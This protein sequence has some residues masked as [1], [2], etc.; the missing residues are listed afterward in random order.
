MGCKILTNFLVIRLNDFLNLYCFLRGFL[1][2]FIVDI[3]QMNRC[4]LR[5]NKNF[6]KITKIDVIME[7]RHSA[8]AVIQPDIELVFFAITIFALN[9]II[10]FLELIGIFC[11]ILKLYF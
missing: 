9:Q 1:N 6:S 7:N 10:K 8:I 11:L 5:V 3:S 2:Y 4:V